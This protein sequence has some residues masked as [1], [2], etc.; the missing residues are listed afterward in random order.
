M[1]QVLIQEL[2]QIKKAFSTKRKTEITFE[3]DAVYNAV[4]QTFLCHIPVL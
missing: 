1:T 2:D 4:H 3:L